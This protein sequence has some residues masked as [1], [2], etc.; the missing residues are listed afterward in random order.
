MSSLITTMILIPPFVALLFPLI[1]NDKAIKYLSLSSYIFNLIVS[2]LMLFDFKNGRA[3]FEEKILWINYFNIY[4]HLDADILSLLMI[5][6]TNF[7]MVISAWS[8]F[9]YIKTSIRKYYFWLSILSSSIIG[10]FSAKDV[11]LF[12]LFWEAM[13]IPMYFIIGIW[14]G[15]NRI[16][17]TI[18]FFIYTMS[19]SIIMLVGIIITYLNL[20][21]LGINSFEIVDFYRNTLQGNLRLFVFLSFLIA[22]AVKIPLFPFHTW[23]PDAHV[24]APTAGSVILAGVLL[25]MGVYG[26]LRFLIPMFPDLSIKFAPYISGIGVFGVIYAS[27]MAWM[28]KDIKKLVAYSSI[29][30][31]GLVVLGIFSFVGISVNG[32]ILQMINHGISTG[33]LFLMIGILY[34]RT[35]TRLIEN[36]GGIFKIVPFIS[37]FFM[38]ITLSSIAVPSTNGFIGEIS[39]FLGAFK[40]Y[41]ILTLLS[42]SGVIL[43]AVY[44]LWAY[45]KMF[46]G[47]ITNQDNLKLTDM[48]LREYLYMIPVVIMIFFIG[49]YPSFFTDLIDIFVNDFL[50]IVGG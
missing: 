46:F 11:F 5:L 49:I 27:L 22:F 32:A 43:G 30:H 3:N 9:N 16:Y 31:M 33:G 29:A 36:Y 4:Y 14:G 15:N 48:N 7:I 34:E 13:L 37:S 35:H 8:S 18:K 1:K 24:E 12:Y 21:S 41:N 10:V 42:I 20:K 25:K 50:K 45:E 6:L 40:K 39:I 44:M 19:A 26:Y 28:Q 47:N 23:L 38:I 17:A 2:I